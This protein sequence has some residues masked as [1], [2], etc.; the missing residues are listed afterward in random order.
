MGDRNDAMMV[1]SNRN[2]YICEEAH[3]VISSESK[4]N[5]L[6]IR[7]KTLSQPGFSAENKTCSCFRST[8]LAMNNKQM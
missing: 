8:L 2:Y 6:I 1:S 5:I 3:E 7:A 4:G